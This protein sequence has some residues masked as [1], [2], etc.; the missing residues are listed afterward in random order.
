MSGKREADRRLLSPFRWE[1]TVSNIAERSLH[2][3]TVDAIRRSFEDNLFYVTG[4]T[5]DNASPDDLYTALAYT[6]RDRLLARYVASVQMP[7]S[8]NHCKVTDASLAAIALD[9]NARP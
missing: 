5:F 1:T 3:R 8:G 7:E 4:R 9:P 6:V 2:T